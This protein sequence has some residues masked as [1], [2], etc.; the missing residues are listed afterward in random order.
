MSGPDTRPARPELGAELELT[1]D[2]LA[3]GGNGIARTEGGYVVFVSGAIPGDRVRARITKRKRAYAEA[4][5]V[6]LLDAVSR[7][8]R[9]RR[10]PPRRAVAGAAVR[11]PARDQ[12]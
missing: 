6:E 4:R 10:R 5:T 9:R 3:Y 2:A 8:H 11:A 12:G 7:A 1:V